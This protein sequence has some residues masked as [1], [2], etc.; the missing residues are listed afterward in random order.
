MEASGEAETVNNA[1][2]TG[3]PLRIPYTTKQGIIS[4]KQG[5]LVQEQGISPANTEI[6]AEY[7]FRYTW[8]SHISTSAAISLVRNY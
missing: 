7:G 8:P 1:V 2:V 6:V 4:A 5:I 3:L